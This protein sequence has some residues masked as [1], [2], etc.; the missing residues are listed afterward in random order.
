MYIKK[1]VVENFMPYK[2]KY[3]LNFRRRQLVGILGQYDGDPERSNR[4]GKSSFV[5]AILWC[6]YG[7]SRA[8]RDIEL[9]HTGQERTQVTVE[10]FEPEIEKATIITRW[11]TNENKGGLE[12]KGS[13]GEKKKASQA[14]IDKIIGFD[15]EEFLFTAFFKQNDIDQFMNADPQKKKQILMKWLQVTNWNKYEEIAGEYKKALNER[16]IKLKGT[17]EGIQGDNIDI[18]EV[19]N[20]LDSLIEDKKILE[21]AIK[22]THEQKIEVEVQLKEMDKVESKKA[23]LVTIGSKIQELELQRPDSDE[24]NQKLDILNEYLNKYPEITQ[25]RFEAATNKKEEII[26]AI[27]SGSVKYNDLGRKLAA[28][29]K[30][31]TGICPVLGESCDRITASPEEITKYEDL[32]VKIEEGKL[33]YEAIKDKAEKIIKLYNHQVKWKNEKNNLEEKSKFAASIEKQIGEL[34]I[35][36][37]EVSEEIPHDLEEMIEGHHRKLS[38]LQKELIGL[39]SKRDELQTREGQISEMLRQYK[40]IQDRKEATEKDLENTEIELA[41]AQYVAYMFGKNGIPSIELENSFQEIENDANYVLKSLK[42]PFNL[43][44]QST[45]ELRD[46]EANCLACGTI[47]TRGEKTHICTKCKT[48]RQKKRRDEL[49]LK[50]FE[51]SNERQFYMDSGGGKILLSVAIRLALTQLARR[52]KGSVWGSIFLD[53]VF[54]ALDQTNRRAMADLVTSTLLESLG[55]DQIFLI[56]HDPNVQSSLADT[57]TVNRHSEGGFSEITFN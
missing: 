22:Q 56:S 3:E 23:E 38:H 10:L 49:S 28:L 2:G 51:G 44:F 6:L 1:V 34:R 32:M 27:S 54:G 25:E 33:K 17:L 53:E 39:E 48:P 57:L 30:E 31:R 37:K 40:T 42:A 55:F 7:K 21:A 5:D 13:E 46:W 11:R 47:F 26:A 16:L 29:Q 4:S 50:V 35:K 19:R 15:H 45:R 24:F 12:L 9:V 18:K 14:Q 41:D 8:K 36:R 20:E 43:E 52:R